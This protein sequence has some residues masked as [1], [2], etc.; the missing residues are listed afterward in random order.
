VVDPDMAGPCTEK[1]AQ[2]SINQVIPKGANI[3]ESTIHQSIPSKPEAPLVYPRVRLVEIDTMDSYR[4]LISDNIEY[5][6]LCQQYGTER[7]D[8]IMELI[9]ETVCS[10]RESIRIAGDDYPRE[11]VKSRLLKITSQHVKYVFDCLDKNTTKVRSIKAYLLTALDNAPATIDSYYRA[12]VQYDLY[13][14]DF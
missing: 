10:T 6:H 13:G 9:L 8:E 4:E 5:L 14:G 3:H 1:A 7:M 2:L 12:E 11:V